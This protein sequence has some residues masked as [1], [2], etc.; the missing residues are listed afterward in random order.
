[1][2]WYFPDFNFDTYPNLNIV[3]NKHP[4]YMTVIN[5]DKSHIHIEAAHGKCIDQSIAQSPPEIQV[6]L[7][8]V[9]SRY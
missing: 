8:H 2:S 9:I 4:N 6:F 7:K 3:Q 5:K 1:M